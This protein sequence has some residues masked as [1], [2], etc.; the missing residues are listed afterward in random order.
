MWTWLEYI[1]CTHGILKQKI[2][3]IF[4][5]IKTLEE[6]GLIFEKKTNFILRLKKVKERWEENSIYDWQPKISNMSSL[7]SS[8]VPRLVYFYFYFFFYKSI[9]FTLTISTAGDEK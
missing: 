6:H 8:L 2:K 1:I 3:I 5:K 9:V 7:L 4:V